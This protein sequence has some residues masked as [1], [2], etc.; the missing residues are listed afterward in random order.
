MIPRQSGSIIS[1]GSMSAVQGGVG[2]HA[3]CCSKHAVVGFMKNAAMELGQFGIRVNCLSPYLIVTPMAK[4]FNKLDVEAV[5]EYV[6]NLKGV[7]DFFYF[8]LYITL[9]GIVNFFF[10]SM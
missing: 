3:Y 5:E 1:T 9:L 6:V 2:S 7:V 10:H 8:F 4:D